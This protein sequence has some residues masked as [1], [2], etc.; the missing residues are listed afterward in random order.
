MRKIF[1]TIPLMLALTACGTDSDD[2]SVKATI[3]PHF[4]ALGDSIPFGYSPLFKM[5]AENVADGKFV[6]YP[7]VLANRL[8]YELANASCSGETTSSMIDPTL[9]DNG[10]HSGEAPN[11]LVRKV[12]YE[13][14]QLAYA[15]SFLRENKDTKLVTIN[16]GGNDILLVESTCNA[17]V[18][19][20]PCK[21]L[22]II[23]VLVTFGKNLVK[24]NNE[25]RSS[26][27]LGEIVFV[28]NYARNYLDGIQKVAL[29]LLDTEAKAIGFLH[30]FKVVSGFKVF[31]KESE[32]YN[33]DACSAGLII[34][35]PEGGC[36]QHPSEKGH[37]VL[38]RAVETLISAK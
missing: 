15:A 28:T 23:P 33:G 22:K 4:L 38:A 19:P 21:F 11:N 35:L 32:D 14:S 26:G 27:Y 34:A 8:G 29:G 20:E 24:I 10:C 18:L 5:T 7:E 16:I 17:Q 25:L 3:G 9:P 36:N 31:E 13:G 1:A 37:E 2:S 6:G 12:A 30:K